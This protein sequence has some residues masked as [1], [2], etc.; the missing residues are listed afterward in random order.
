MFNTAV[1]AATTI[2]LNVYARYLR[3][4]IGQRKAF[5]VKMEPETIAWIKA[6]LA[7]MK[8]RT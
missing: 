7:K 1:F 8:P 6:S 4:L 3:A 5:F 2:Y